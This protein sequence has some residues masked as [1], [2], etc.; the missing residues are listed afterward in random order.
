MRELRFTRERHRAVA[1]ALAALDG[2][3]LMSAACAFAGGTR[4]VL[5]LDEYRESEDLD[6]LCA[7][8]A[9]YRLL[10]SEVTHTSLGKILRAPMRLARE[11]R[12]DRYG[13]RTVLDVAGHLLKFEMV[14]EGR[15]AIVAEAVPGTEVPCLDQVSCVAEKFLANADRG[16]DEAFLGRDVIDL[17]FMI[18]A[19]GVGIAKKGLAVAREVYGDVVVKTAGRAAVRM[20]E[21]SAW[22]TRCITRLAVSGTPRLMAGLRALV[23]TT[24]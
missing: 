1:V 23:K 11:V 17:S 16:L 18:D 12:A 21:D 2:N 20:L 6:F 10:R 3:F 14:L 9:G 15:I 13:I 8:T 19:W 4:I 22:R 7:D 5:E 24:R